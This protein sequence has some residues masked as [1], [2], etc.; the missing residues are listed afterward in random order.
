MSVY[1]V[2]SFNVSGSEPGDVMEDVEFVDVDHVFS[3]LTRANRYAD[4]HIS[5][6]KGPDDYVF[7]EDDDEGGFKTVYY[8]SN[9]ELDGPPEFDSFNG[10]VVVIREVGFD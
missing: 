7:V 1:V 2:Y 8:I 9:E 4:R 5:E 3:S 10:W 6:N